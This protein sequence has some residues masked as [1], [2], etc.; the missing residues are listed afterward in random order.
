MLVLLVS[1]LVVDPVA[2]LSTWLKQPERPALNQQM[3]SRVPLTRAQAEA[4]KDLIVTDSMTKLRTERAEEWKQRELKLGELKMPFHYTVFGE[5]PAGGRSLYISLHG[6]GN[7]GKRVNDQQW[8]NQQRLYKPQEGVYLSP[9]APKDDWNMWFQDHM[10]AFYARL[11]EDAVLFEDVDI[12]RVYLMG[13]S[14]G[15]DGVFR[16]ATWYADRWAAASMMAG[17]P[18]D[19]KPDNLRNL[20]FSLYMGGQDS[21]YERNKRAEEWK[22][23]LAKIKES[24]PAGYPHEVVIFPEYKH[25][26][27]GKD[28]VAVPWMAKQRRQPTPSKVV[29]D[30]PH[31]GSWYW[32]TGA[33][34]TEG[35]RK[36][37]RVVAEL[38][39]QEI[40]LQCENLDKLT[41]RLRDEMLDL[42]KP[43][44]ILWGYDVVFTGKVDRTIESLHASWQARHDTSLIFPA[45]LTVS[46]P[47]SK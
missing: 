12:N 38:K 42:E 39:A 31:T 2:E 25:W 3:W 40:R 19:V 36:M 21:A 5:K 7:S 45:A 10:E 47:E 35:Q 17:H 15:G 4:A 11:I 29:W 18:G 8:K 9:R 32:L 27:Q 1:L 37:A 13:Y 20:P 34:V 33:Q 6:G 24:D 46:R 43:V 16:L 28:A 26:M 30:Q 23:K 41:L 14:A 44:T 22:V